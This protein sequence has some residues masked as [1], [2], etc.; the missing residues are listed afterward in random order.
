MKNEILC[1]DWGTSSFRLRLVQV[2]DLHVTGEVSGQEG[3]A[4][5][6]NLWQAARKNSGIT[7]EGFFRQQL[8]VHTKALE[9][10]I[11]RPLPKTTLVISGMASSSIGLEELPYG[12]LPFAVDGSQAYVR[13]Y[14]SKSDFPFD[15]LLI[16][17]VRSGQDV[18]R[19]EETQLVGLVA[20][21]DTTHLTNESVFIFPGT[22]SKHIKIRNQQVTDFQTFMTGEVFNL[23]TQH[24]IL[25]DSVEASQDED[26]SPTTIKAFRLGVQASGQANILHTLFTVR[27]NQLFGTLNKHDNFYYLSGLLIGAELRSLPN[28]STSQLVLSSGSNLFSYYEMAMEELNLLERTVIISPEVID[29]AAIAGQVKIYQHELLQLT[30][31]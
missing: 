12:N 19:G 10:K 1:C 17:G 29:K 3:I 15:V 11:G 5:T 16:S 7:K 24:S 22:H 28:N 6:F 14:K 4:R 23:M 13:F 2:A 25:K 26:L 9:N 21:L 8:L 18:M 27:A 31:S 30:R 20:L